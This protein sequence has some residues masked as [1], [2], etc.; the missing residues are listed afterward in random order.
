M[1]LILKELRIAAMA[2]LV[3]VIICCGI[4]PALIWGLAQGIFPDK[5]N[6]S[7][8]ERKGVIVGSSL[9]GQGFSGD[10]YFHSR[11]SSAGTGYD[12]LHSGGSNLGPLSRTLIETVGQRVKTYRQNNHLA[13]T[14][15]VPV[16][17][18]TTSGSGLDPH[19][20]LLNAQLQVSRVARLR[21]LSDVEVQK[22]VSKY[23][24]SRDL[25]IFGEPRVNV[26]TLNL[27]LDTVVKNHD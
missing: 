15:V 14:I 6:G 26:L 13:A 8:I 4:Y 19:I 17:A 20:S 23:T 9:I 18:V 3:L 27:E 10:R 7:L 2:T 16:D 11:P 1:K 22:M 5:A 24:E 21:G 12:S 25:E